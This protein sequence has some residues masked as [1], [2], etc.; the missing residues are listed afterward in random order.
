LS[1][2]F[3]KFWTRWQFEW[4]NF[5]DFLKTAY[6][7][8]GHPLFRKVDLALLSSYFGH[9]PY[10]ISRR[11]LTERGAEEIYAYGETPLTTLETIVAESGLTSADIIF[12]LGC[13]RGRTCF[14]LALILKAL[15]VGIDFVPEFIRKAQKLTHAFSLLNPTFRCEDFLMSDLT[16]CTVLYLNGTC[17]DDLDI[18]QLIRKFNQLPAGTKAI[19]VSF[20]LSEYA[21]GNRWELIKSFPVPFTW[22]QAEVYVQ[23]LK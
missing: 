2:L 1:T 7:Y 4:R 14:W 18:I 19:T 8:Y 6:R 3:S 13:G 21:E 12:E 20:P 16:G 17:L 11:F 22:G 23:V 9:N 10:R 15:V 5:L